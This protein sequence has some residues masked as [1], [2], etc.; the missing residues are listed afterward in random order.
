MS[1][2]L[3]SE[4]EPLSIATRKGPDLV[5]PNELEAEGLV[6]RE[7]ADEEDRAGRAW[8]RWSSWAR[9]SRS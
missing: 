6:G 9:A 5:S 3:D 8:P 4:G 7:F 1:T 2:V